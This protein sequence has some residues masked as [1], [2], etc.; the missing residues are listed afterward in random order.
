VKATRRGSPYVGEVLEKAFEKAVAVVVLLTPDDEAR[1]RRPYQGSSEP[2]HERNLTPQARPN[3]L[4]EAGMAFGRN[5]MRS[6]IVEIGR[7]RPFTDISGRYGIRF[8]GAVEDRARLKDRLKTAGC[9]V[10]EAGNH[11]YTAGDFTKV[12]ATGHRT[13]A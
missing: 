4:F 9:L 7:V 13:S 6:I 2:A 10:D 1:L 5:P 11:W 8:G 3:V 12:L